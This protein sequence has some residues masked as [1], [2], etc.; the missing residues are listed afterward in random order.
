MSLEALSWQDIDSYFR[1]MRVSPHRWE[2]RAIADL[3]D[4][5]LASRFSETT[6]VVRGAKGLKGR[7]NAA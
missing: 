7:M 2:V 1:L 6:G 5:F 4:A 3:D